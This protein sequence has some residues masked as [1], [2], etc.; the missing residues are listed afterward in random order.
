MVIETE[1]II[2]HAKCARKTLTLGFILFISGKIQNTEEHDILLIFLYGVACGAGG[3]ILIIL[4]LLA[5]S[6]CLKK[7]RRKRS[8]SQRRASTQ[9]T[10]DY[11]TTVCN[12]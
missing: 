4:L 12:S 5:V 2:F 6:C 7:Q 10:K 9:E 3:L 1:V 8:H 11:I